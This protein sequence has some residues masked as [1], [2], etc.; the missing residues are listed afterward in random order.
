MQ[1]CITPRF[2]ASPH[3]GRYVYGDRFVLLLLSTFINI[4]LFAP[5]RIAVTMSS[6]PSVPVLSAVSL[7]QKWRLFLVA[8]GFS[9]AYI[10]SRM[11][12]TAWVSELRQFPG[13]R[14]NA[15]SQLPR[16]YQIWLGND[17]TYLTH[18]HATYGPIVR[19]GPNELSFA[20]GAQAWKD[21][22]GFTKSGLHGMKDDSFYGRPINGA[23]NVRFVEHTQEARLKQ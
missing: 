4:L 8:V 10:I 7:D 5:P 9:I 19:V 17:V 23:P 14:L 18:L 21:I 3:L 16:L 13:P 22:Y 2:T 20:E 12:Y 15:F 1:S 11:V 6:S